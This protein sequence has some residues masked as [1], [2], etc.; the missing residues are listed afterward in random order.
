MK[1]MTASSAAKQ[2]G[3]QMHR[4]MRSLTSARISEDR[5]NRLPRLP[6]EDCR[7]FRF[8]DDRAVVYPQPSDPRTRQHHAQSTNAP[9]LTAAGWKSAIVP[10]VDDAS[11]AFAG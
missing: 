1:L 4:R 5:P 8:G 11:Q 9:L 3:K 10:I 2:T 6:V 7:P